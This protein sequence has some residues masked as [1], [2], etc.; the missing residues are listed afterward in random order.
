VR[1]GWISPSS[2]THQQNRSTC[3]RA[4]S[5][6]PKADPD[7]AHRSP[8]T[9]RRRSHVGSSNTPSAH[10][11]PARWRGT[12]QDTCAAC[13]RCT[14]AHTGARPCPVVDRLPQMGFNCTPTGDAW[15]PAFRQTT[16]RLLRYNAR[17]TRK[18]KGRLG[19]L[20]HTRMRC[21]VGGAAVAAASTAAILAPS[22]DE[23][24][25]RRSL[26]QERSRNKTNRTRDGR[27]RTH[28]HHWCGRCSAK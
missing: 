27:S 14:C 3:N 12:V 19:A 20:H 4:P 6:H 1:V 26:P 2:P 17:A 7:S 9:L 11:T 25:E 18:C 22:P 10:R 24:T 21:A 15:V 8:S 23:I 5:A 28:Q 13:A 16:T